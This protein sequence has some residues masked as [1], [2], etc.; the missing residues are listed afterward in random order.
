MAQ[1]DGVVATSDEVL[2]RLELPRELP[3]LVLPNGVDVQHFAQPDVARE[4]IAIYVGAIDDRLDVEAFDVLADAFPTWS[5]QIFGPGSGS[6]RRGPGNV[7]W[8]G[9]ADYDQLPGLL[10]TARIG[11]LPLSSA[12]TNAG[13]SPMKLYEYLAS[14]LSVL[15]SATPSI[16]ENVDA[17][18]LTYSDRDEMVRKFDVLA[19]GPLVNES[20]RR[21][22]KTHGWGS[23]AL[24]LISFA[25]GI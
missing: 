8:R 4:R 5:F 14:G 16:G 7:S 9:A 1:A 15:S 20:G 10:A 6:L 2:R 12:P 25:E 19:R 22:A 24:Q 13:R 18:L 3:N 21:E 23:K 17:Q 11:L